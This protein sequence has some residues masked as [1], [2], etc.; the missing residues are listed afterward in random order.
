MVAAGNGLEELEGGCTWE[1]AAVVVGLF[2]IHS[3]I[4]GLLN[5]AVA[6]VPIRAISATMIVVSSFLEDGL[7]TF[8]GDGC[9]DTNHTPTN[10]DRA[11]T[12]RVTPLNQILLN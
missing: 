8:L 10:K 7:F 1:D 6:M 11:W 2:R 9:F 4:T 12:V 5:R 3:R